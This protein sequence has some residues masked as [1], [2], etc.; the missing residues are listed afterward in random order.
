[1]YNWQ[2]P[3]NQISCSIFYSGVGVISLE[4]VGVG[5]FCAYRFIVYVNFSSFNFS[6][7]QWALPGVLPSRPEMFCGPFI[8]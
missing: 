2:N 6:I 3:F 5:Q 8:A 1:M 7:L 4:C